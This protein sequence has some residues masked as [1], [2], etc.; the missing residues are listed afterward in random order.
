VAVVGPLPY[1]LNVVYGPAATTPQGYA[2]SYILDH[3]Q[4][5][6]MPTDENGNAVT[7]TGQTIAIVNWA[8]NPFLKHDLLFF[9]K[10]FGLADMDGLAGGTCTLAT[11]GGTPCFQILNVGGTVPNPGD[12]AD[13]QESAMDIEWAHAAA[14][15]ANIIAVQ[16]QAPTLY[17]GSYY[18]TNAGLDAAIQAGVTAGATVV[19]MSWGAGSMTD[20]D[21]ATWDGLNVGFVSGEGDNGFPDTTYPPRD[22]N[23]LSVGG[24]N[25]TPTAEPDW[26]YSGGGVTTLSRPG[27]Q[28]N[29]VNSS[30]REV[31]DVAYNAAGDFADGSPA[32][33]SVAIQYNT[34]HGIQWIQEG[35]VSAGI[36]QW[37]GIV[38]DTDQVRVSRGI[39]ILARSGL[40]SGLYLAAGDNEQRTDVVNPAYFND[41]STGCAYKYA[42]PPARPVPPCASSAVDGYDPTTGLGTPRVGDLVDYL[43]YDI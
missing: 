9:D 38:A 35:G 13:Y 11:Y 33:Y 22:P 28:L 20:A 2:P 19:S 21:A 4:F 41:I 3:Y 26:I 24:T 14:P 30:D 32:F 18:P 5:N 36:P 1:H 25:L 12:K 17:N 8:N 6:D 16:A 29:W 7:G 10:Q 15:G 39:S 34:T 27:Y 23:V 43:G 31:N 40:M 37:A 42:A